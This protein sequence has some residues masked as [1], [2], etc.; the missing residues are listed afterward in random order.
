MT[1]TR[2]TNVILK[3]SVDAPSKVKLTIHHQFPGIGL[4][5]PICA[6][7]GITCY[8]LP[9]RSVVVG[10]TTQAGFNINPDENESIGI[11]MYELKRKNTDQP[12]EEA[13][14][15]KRV[16]IQLVMIWKVHKSGRFYVYSFLIEHDNSRVWYEYKLMKLVRY[17][18]SF[19]IQHGPIEDT[20]LMHNNTVLMIRANVTFEEEYYK[21]EMTIS[22]G[23]INKDTWRIWYIH[24]FW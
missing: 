14:S 19:I 9:D 11:L 10:F 13:I 23:S 1:S 17:C 18:K 21:L 4:V 20:W 3:Q 16:Y 8:L 5:S 2:D 12:N 24:W 7:K 22:E 15:N 6:G